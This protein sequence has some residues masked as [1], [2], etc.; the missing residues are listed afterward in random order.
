MKE[1]EYTNH[2]RSFNNKLELQLKLFG[3][4]ESIGKFLAEFMYSTD[5]G[6]SSASVE[7]MKKFG[8]EVT[9]EEGL[10]F[11]EFARRFDENGTTP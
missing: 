2:L 8:S 10:A 4:D 9:E 3:I 7:I 6:R 1:Q 11:I 5:S